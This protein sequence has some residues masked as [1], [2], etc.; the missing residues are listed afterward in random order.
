MEC[1]QYMGPNIA[2]ERKS[3]ERMRDQENMRA[4]R[5]ASRG[6][7]SASAYR[8]LTRHVGELDSRRAM[9]MPCAENE[10]RELVG[11]ERGRRRD[12]GPFLDLFRDGCL[13]DEGGGGGRVIESDDLREVNLVI[14]HGRW[15]CGCRGL[16]LY[17]RADAVKHFGRGSEE[18]GGDRG[19][20]NDRRL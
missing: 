12:G 14:E 3:K 1:M 6:L 4:R 9:P 10:A 8:G 7:C 18:G 15:H 5:F 19:R 16:R 17:P 20:A 11:R 2:R 13:T